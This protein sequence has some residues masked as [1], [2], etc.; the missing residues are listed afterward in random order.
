MC[1][2]PTAEQQECEHGGQMNKHLDQSDFQMFERGLPWDENWAKRR[3]S[4]RAAVSGKP[5]CDK[6]RGMGGPRRRA[7]PSVSRPPPA[8][9]PQRHLR[10]G[11]V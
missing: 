11:F 2:V 1:R 3:K 8:A 10:A 6:C 5:V 7:P 9:P 4:G